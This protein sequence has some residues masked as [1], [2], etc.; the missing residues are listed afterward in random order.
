LQRSKASCAPFSLGRSPLSRNPAVQISWGELID[1]I[2]I[3][4]IKSERLTAQQALHNVRHEL[5]VLT[6][7]LEGIV[8]SPSLSQLRS[9]LWEIN[10][11]LWQI[12]NS[13]RNKEAHKEFDQEF[14]DL[15]R[16]VY[17]MNDERGRIKR[18]INDLLGSELIEEKQYTSY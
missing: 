1:K 18:E 17:I 8:M 16:S 13:I 14:V 2:T 9:R 5:A 6:R 4:E 15:A 3:L 7:P 10:E 12:E 11:R